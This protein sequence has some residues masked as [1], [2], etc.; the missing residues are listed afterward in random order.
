MIHIDI[1]ENYKHLGHLKSELKSAYS[2][3][4][5]VFNEDKSILRP[6]FNKS[7]MIIG[8]LEQGESAHSMGLEDFFL[9]YSED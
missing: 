8:G 6:Q 5:F 3:Y 7:E 9:T 2:N 4:T 1:P